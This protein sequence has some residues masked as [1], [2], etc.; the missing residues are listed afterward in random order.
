MSSNNDH[1]FASLLQHIKETQ[2]VIQKK[3][4]ED[5]IA[6]EAGS[7]RGAGTRR[8]VKFTRTLINEVKYMEE[9]LKSVD[10]QLVCGN[11]VPS[12]E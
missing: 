7:F 4:R 1:L 9:L 5:A 3:Q 10:G 2:V 6:A 11:V 12:I 8:S